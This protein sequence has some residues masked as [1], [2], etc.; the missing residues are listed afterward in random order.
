MSQKTYLKSC[1][2]LNEIK[3]NS[4]DAIITDP[5]YG[6]NLEK[7]DTMPNK[8]I[9][10]DCYRVLKPGGFL[11]CFSSIQFLHLFTTQILE[12]NFLF[13]DTLNWVFLNGRVPSINLDQQIDD[14][15]GLDRPIIGEYK[16]QQGVP[17]SKK[18][19]TYTNTQKKIKTGATE[20]SAPWSGFGTGLKTAY[21]PILIVQKPMEG[22]LA[23]N[24]LN[25]GVGAFNLENTR[26]PYDKNETAVGHNPHP[27]GR[28]MPNI[29]QTEEFGDYQ[30]FF[31][32]GKVRDGKRTG[33]I[34]PT[35]KPNNL[36]TQLVE[37]VTKENMIILDPFMGSGSTG[38]A[39]L[40][41]NRSFI[42]YET[43]EKYYEIAV[44]RIN[45]F[46]QH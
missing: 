22:S 24:V 23:E 14:Y 28:V 18:K 13:K 21:E 45:S 11:I 12:A 5:P 4:I 19:S 31:F 38:V 37:L 34:H 10:E 46:K 9:W 39:A 29:I 42:G 16:Y 35:V 40:Q 43:E 20:Q 26:I 36:M 32:V 7:W 25:Y 8:E 44:N 3:D 17:S 41:L 2:G 30:K 27:K 1:Y 33:N 6:I 15:L